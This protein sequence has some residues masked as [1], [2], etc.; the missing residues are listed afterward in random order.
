MPDLTIH[1]VWKCF[2][3]ICVIALASFGIT[4]PALASIGV[5]RIYSTS[6]DMV[7]FTDSQKSIEHCGVQFVVELCTI[8]NAPNDGRI[9]E[10]GIFKDRIY[11]QAFKG[12][13]R[14]TLNVKLAA[15]ENRKPAKFLWLLSRPIFQFLTN[16]EAILSPRLSG[17]QI[18]IYKKSTSWCFTDVVKVKVDIEAIGFIHS[19]PIKSW[20]GNPGALI[21]DKGIAALL[22]GDV[23]RIKL[24]GENDSSIS[25]ESGSYRSGDHHSDIYEQ[26]CPFKTITIPFLLAVFFLCFGFWCVGAAENS[27]WWFYAAIACLVACYAFV[28]VGGGN[29]ACHYL[30]PPHRFAKK[31]LI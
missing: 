5:N 28:V 6:D 20:R 9:F 11:G 29:L 19:F 12:I 14:H 10:S 15:W 13:T 21:R 24:T 17:D 16:S 18:C 26:S 27:D 4:K 23:H 31:V 3:I 25:G 7:I 30:H 22:V 1:G 2:V 8:D